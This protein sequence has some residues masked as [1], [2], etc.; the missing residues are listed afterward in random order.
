MLDSILC[1]DVESTEESGVV[2]NNML[3]EQ[4]YVWMAMD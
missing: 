4:E 1:F 2:L 3:L